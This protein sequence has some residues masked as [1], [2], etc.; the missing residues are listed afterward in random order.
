[1]PNWLMAEKQTCR[2]RMSKDEFISLNLK[3]EEIGK[4]VTKGHVTLITS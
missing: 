4:G 2:L 3:I 1:M